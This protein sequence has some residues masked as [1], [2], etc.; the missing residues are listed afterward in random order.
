MTLRTK[1]RFTLLVIAVFLALPSTV[2][3]HREGCDWGAF[4][5]ADCF[6]K[7]KHQLNHV[8]DSV[9]E[10]SVDTWNQVE[11]TWNAVKTETGRTVIDIAEAT[12]TTVNDIDQALK[13]MEASAETF[14][15]DVLDRINLTRQE[16]EYFINSEIVDDMVAFTTGPNGCSAECQELRADLLELINRSEQVTNTIMTFG[17]DSQLFEGSV[18]LQVFPEVDY[19][20]LHDLLS[21]APGAILYPIHKAVTTLELAGGPGSPRFLG[22]LNTTLSNIDAS[23][24]FMAGLIKAPA[25]SESTPQMAI[26]KGS[27]R[28]EALVSAQAQSGPLCN[29]LDE[30]YEHD[31][32][33]D[34]RY[35]VDRV[36]PYVQ[37]SGLLLRFVG[38]VL[39]AVGHTEGEVVTEVGW[40]GY[41]GVSMKDNW[42]KK[43]GTILDVIGSVSSGMASGVSGKLTSCDLQSL[44]RESSYIMCMLENPASAGKNPNNTCLKLKPDS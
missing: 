14:S 43:I 1:H 18:D 36:I 39:K 33:V 32:R 10:A 15:Q 35:V 42:P 21:D 20:V 28:L 2:Q 24:V 5:L 23:I 34:N 22:S 11:E 30:E 27:N 25:I 17:G 38:G 29:W 41:V 8:F 16:V 12:E 4:A 37:G 3:A 19:Q 13:D 7:V 31:T 40:F 26:N 44:R 6:E 9:S